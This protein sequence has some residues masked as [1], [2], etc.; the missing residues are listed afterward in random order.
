MFQRI[1]RSSNLPVKESKISMDCELS[2][3]V[4]GYLGLTFLGKANK[5]I[6]Y[7]ICDNTI[8]TSNLGSAY[9]QE[10]DHLQDT[11]ILKPDPRQSILTDLSMVISKITDDHH[12]VVVMMDLNKALDPIKQT[13]LAKSVQDNDL[14]DAHHNN[15]APPTNIFCSHRCIDDVQCVLHQR[16]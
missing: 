12:E 2:G 10:W 7:H 4:V 16:L 1:Q 8:N 13:G 11:G 9:S 6:T 3:I 14:H 5:K 15:Q